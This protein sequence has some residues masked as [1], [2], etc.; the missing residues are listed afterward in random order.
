MRIK[1]ENR[2][3]KKNHS[4]ECRAVIF[5]AFDRDSKGTDNED[6][7]RSFPK[8]RWEGRCKNESNFDQL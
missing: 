7:M 3:K 5:Q 4:E 2:L 1:R 6:I 8:H